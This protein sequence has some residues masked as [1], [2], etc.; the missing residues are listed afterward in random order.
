MKTTRVHNDGRLHTFR[1]AHLQFFNV[2]KHHDTRRLSQENNHH[3]HHKNFNPPGLTLGKARTTP[4]G[5]Y[6]T[7][8]YLP[9]LEVHLYFQFFPNPNPH[10]SHF[11]MKSLLSMN[12]IHGNQ[13]RH[14]LTMNELYGNL[15]RPLLYMDELSSSRHMHLYFLYSIES[16]ANNQ[17]RK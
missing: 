2:K 5:F 10:S 12:E 6:H 15:Y 3:H 14:F 16:C 17:K 11:C 13:Q 7:L 9:F 1:K 4:M 8:I